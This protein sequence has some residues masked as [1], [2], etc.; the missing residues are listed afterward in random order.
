MTLHRDHIDL[1]P[2]SAREAVGRYSGLR[3]EDARPRS[4]RGIRVIAA[5]GLATAIVACGAAPVVAL[6]ARVG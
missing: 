4:A 2:M 6:L 1:S 5:A 3:R